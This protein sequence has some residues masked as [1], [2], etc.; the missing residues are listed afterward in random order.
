MFEPRAAFSEDPLETLITVGAQSSI[1]KRPST[2]TLHFATC[3]YKRGALLNGAK[4]ILMK[5]AP[6]GNESLPIAA[7]A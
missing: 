3:F 6:T 2:K 5:L 4:T 1:A 7:F